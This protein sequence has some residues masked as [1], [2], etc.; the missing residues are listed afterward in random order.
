MSHI[1][2]LFFPKMK[3]TEKKEVEVR[4]K[5]EMIVFLS[6]SNVGFVIFLKKNCAVYYLKVYIN[7]FFKIIYIFKINM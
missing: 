7:N 5:S 6:E 2:F 1:I 4:L 3:R